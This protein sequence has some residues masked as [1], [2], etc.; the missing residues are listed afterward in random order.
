LDCKAAAESSSDRASFRKR[1]R[2]AHIE[3]FYV[4]RDVMRATG[5]RRVPLVAFNV[6]PRL[7]LRTQIWF[8]THV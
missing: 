6:E 5:T 8:L 1:E 7:L 4:Q 2:S 3:G